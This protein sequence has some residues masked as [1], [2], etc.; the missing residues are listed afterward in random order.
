[1]IRVSVREE[2]EQ[3][4]LL[5]INWGYKIVDTNSIG[6]N[7]GVEGSSRRHWCEGDEEE[8]CSEYVRGPSC[9]W[10]DKRVARG[11]Q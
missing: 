11:P 3:G 1:M 10:R 8:R 9:L 7:E 2:V 5:D 4:G 6:V